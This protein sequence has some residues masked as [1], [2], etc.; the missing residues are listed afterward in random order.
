MTAETRNS[1]AD[2]NPI[3]QYNP[4]MSPRDSDPKVSQSIDT[5]PAPKRLGP[6][7]S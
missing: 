2:Y 6:S 7:P 3:K 5:I 4:M 1:K